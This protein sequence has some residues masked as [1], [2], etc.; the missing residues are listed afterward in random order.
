MS[1]SLLRALIVLALTVPGNIRAAEDAPRLAI[2]RIEFVADADAPALGPPAGGSRRLNCYATQEYALATARI[3]GPPIVTDM[4][5]V[6]YCWED[7]RIELTPA[8]VQ[9]WESLGGWHVPLDGI[10]IMV[11]VDGEPC[12]AALMW[13]PLSSMGSTLPQMWGKTRE[14]RVVVGGVFVSAA[15][16]TIRGANFDPR[17]E[18]VMS[19]LG[20]LRPG[21]ATE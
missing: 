10:P 5:I 4:D 20:K 7:Q 17:V 11:V 14:G 8:G 1:R 21:C 3:V 19:E 13:T 18:Q 9:R 6:A 15:G 16:D 12:Y 2:H